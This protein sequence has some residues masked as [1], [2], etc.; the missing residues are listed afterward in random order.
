MFKSIY[1]YEIKNWLRSPVSY[2]VVVVLFAFALVTILGTGGFFDGVEQTDKEVRLLNSSHEILFMFQYFNKLLL[3]LVPVF[4]GTSLYKDYQSGTYKISYSFPINKWVYLAAKYLSSFSICICLSLVIGIALVTGELIL[5]IA[6]PKIGPFQMTGY[7]LAYLVYVIPN[8]FIFGGFIFVIVG[9]SRNIYAAFICTLIFFLLQILVR[10]ILHDNATLLTLLDPFGQD[11]FMYSVRNWN[12]SDHNN[13]VPDIVGSILVN[14]VFWIVLAS[15]CLASFSLKFDFLYE[16]N[17]SFK[18]LSSSRN[19]QP[20]KQ[21]KKVVSSISKVEYDHSFGSQMRRMLYLARVDFRYMIK[22]WIFFIFSIFGAVTIF[23][24]LFRITNSGEFNLMPLT[25]L[26]LSAPLSLYSIILMLAIFVYAGLL[27]HRGKNQHMNLLM[28]ATTTTNASFLFS[29]VLALGLLILSFLAIM[30][31]CGISIQVYN[32][33]YDFEIEQYLFHL[34]FISFP[35]LMIWAMLAVFIHNLIPNLYLGL[36][37]LIFAWIGFDNLSQVGLDSKLLHFNAASQMSYDD[38]NGYAGQLKGHFIVASYWLMSGLIMLCLSLVIWR[39]G[40]DKGILQRLTQTSKNV[41]RPLV[42]TLVVITVAFGLLG[43]KIYGGEMAEANRSNAYAN[44]D[45]DLFKDQFREYANIKQPKIIDI[46]LDIDLYPNQ[47][48]FKATGNYVL[49]NKSSVPQDTVLI[50]AGFDEITNL[51]ISR[52]NTLIEADSV[53]QYYI[54]KLVDPLLPNE[55]MVLD[56]DIESV[57]NTLF[58][59]N[60][61]VLQNGSYIKQDILPRLQYYFNDEIKLPSDSTVSFENYYHS[62]A[63]LVSIETNI[64]TTNDQIAIAPG[65]LVAT[66]QEGRRTVYSYKTS[67]PIKF[68]FSFHSAE[69]TRTEEDY[70]G[71]SIE[72][73]TNANHQ[74]NVNSMIGGLKAALDYNTEWFGDYPHQRIRIIEFPHTEES[75]SATL[76]SN[77]I[78]TSEVLFTIN[79][80]A[81]AEK[82]NLPFYVMAHEL[83]HEWFGNQMMPAKSQGAKML[84][85]SIT[86]YISLKIY[87]QAFGDEMGRKFLSKQHN[88]YLDGHK[89]EN[90][91]EHPLSHVRSEQQYIAYGK[92]AIAFNTLSHYLGENN[93]NDLLASFL[94]EYKNKDSA[95]PT[96]LDFINYLKAN[97]ETRFHNLVT[98]YFKQA[99]LLDLEIGEDMRTEGT[100]LSLS[101]IA[102]KYDAV[103][104]EKVSLTWQRV[105]VGFLNELNEII[106]IEEVV[107]NANMSDF[108]FEIPEGAKSI[109]LDPDRLIIDPE[110]DNNLV[111]I[112]E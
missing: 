79:E 18:A 16:N 57:D 110:L 2:V 3:F 74:S 103:T 72:V 96:S 19:S 90:N 112:D 68:N 88:R 35:A 17:W 65:D 56:F 41:S 7:L 76:M 107:L 44:I 47:H 111:L 6:N 64:T 100:Q 77:N 109:M 32:G 60:S 4:F 62:D 106:S 73:F 89:K 63:D 31:I 93:F 29:K 69:Y 50:K 30:M 108:I 87:E 22:S 98:E 101:I 67:H 85:E 12:L 95:Y 46:K 71:V 86:E 91:V 102:D 14:R 36:F 83:T 58:S 10:N 33:Y 49:I 52:P 20:L 39:R 27:V 55:S 70:K 9:V 21:S 34:I 23:F 105:Q 48:S 37:V 28:D 42:M 38:F 51:V 11:A 24:I 78:P 80:Q 61:C 26:M 66:K 59:R 54:F 40:I 75:Y 84:T 25:R 8:F 1:L 82:L 94:N 15:L 97:I 43:F 104:N 45:L 13:L 81:M 5:G 92:G 99:V 53:M